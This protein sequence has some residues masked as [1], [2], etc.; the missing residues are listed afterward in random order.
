VGYDRSVDSK[1]RFSFTYEPFVSAV[2]M[3]ATYLTLGG[4]LEEGHALEERAFALAAQFNHPQT[5]GVVYA[6]G[7]MRRFALGDFGDL[8]KQA[9]SM[10]EHGERHSL[11]HWNRWAS[12]YLG[13]SVALNGN[14]SQGLRMIDEALTNFADAEFTFARAHSLQVR[15]KALQDAGD[16]KTALATLE[17]ARAHGDATGEQVFR[18]DVLRQTGELYLMQDKFEEAR[19]LFEEAIIH[20]RRQETRLFELRAATSL[21]RLWRGQGKIAEAEAVLRPIWLT[22]AGGFAAPVIDD[23]TW[24]F[25]ELSSGGRL[26]S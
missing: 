14:L 23:A 8:E 15:A 9:S 18:A 11:A 2:N 25:D 17:S 20:A 3:R 26:V 7:L 10:I 4:Q 1:L 5:T 22:F 6:F 13:C 12:I 21:A 19:N 24:V 16:L